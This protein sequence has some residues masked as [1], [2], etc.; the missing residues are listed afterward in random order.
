VSRHF[1]TDPFPG[2]PRIL[3]VGHGDSSHT[4]SWIELLE[5][6]EIN[7]RLFSLPSG[8][9]PQTWPVRTYV[10]TYKTPAL[11][12]ATRR[13][14]FSH[15]RIARLAKY[16]YAQV[17]LS[18]VRRLPERWLA[19][20]VREWRPDVI[21]TF[22]L[23]GGGEFYFGA[24]ERYGLGGIGR[25]LL[26]L[27]GASDLTLD[28][29]DPERAPF[30]RRILADADQVLADNRVDLGFACELGV[31]ERQITPM[32]TVPGTGG[33]D[34]EALASRWQGPTSSR[35][36][37]LWPKAYEFFQSKALPVFEALKIA[38]DRLGDCEIVMLAAQPETI[39]WHRTLPEPI[40]RASRIVERIPRREVLEMM[41][42]ARV[43]LA[44]SLLDGTPN[45][46]FE[47]MASGAFPILSPLDAIRAVVED[48]TNT[49]FARN[50]YPHEIADALV[51]A[52]SDDVLVDEA[53]RR[54]LELVGRIASRDAIRPTIV[55]YYHALAAG[56]H[57]ELAR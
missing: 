9:P 11:D 25:W 10:S 41:G 34:F 21:H 26:Q 16:G 47:A 14:L 30:L 46:M 6:A 22:G 53:S 12:Q 52:M 5:G 20:V 27:R 8:A 29:L 39:A 1:D 15:R 40:R 37:I 45:A 32:V 50:L 56:A 18:S 57:A 4:H 23:R 48:G 35:R 54:N 55:E 17:A 42:R 49:L 38:W 13:Q 19:S 51:R 3:F 36:L 31:S 2:R 44:P 7:V 28:R 24:R 43:M 33:V